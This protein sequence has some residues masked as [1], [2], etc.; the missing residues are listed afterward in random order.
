MGIC[1]NSRQG[2]FPIF[3]AFFSAILSTQPVDVALAVPAH[4]VVAQEAGEAVDAV[5]DLAA[6]GVGA[7]RYV[8]DE[9]LS[10][11]EGQGACVKYVINSYQNQ[12]YNMFIPPGPQPELVPVAVSAQN[13]DVGKFSDVVFPW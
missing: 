13:F 6:A 7:G 3:Q 1:Q 8:T 4:G 9:S 11:I 5:V 12:L 10:S 2:I